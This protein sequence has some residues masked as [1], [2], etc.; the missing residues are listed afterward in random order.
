[1]GPPY[2]QPNRRLLPRGTRTPSARARSGR[3]LAAFG[4]GDPLQPVAAPG[5]ARPDADE[6]EEGLAAPPPPH[7]RGLVVPP[8]HADLGDPEPAPA[9]DVERLHVEGEAVEA[10][11]TERL[12]RGGGGEELEAALRVPE[13]GKDEEAHEDVE[14]P[15]H[16]FPVPGLAHHDVRRL[17]G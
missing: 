12:L 9:G 4:G 8:R 15:A 1:P 17:E 14:D 11:G 7:G 3:S 10:G 16:A 6:V 5:R 13:V 2:H